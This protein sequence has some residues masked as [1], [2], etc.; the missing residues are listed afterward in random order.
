VFK[1][2]YFSHINSGTNA[3]PD[4]FLFHGSFTRIL[5]ISHT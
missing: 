5:N 1:F 2:F 4:Q 3:E